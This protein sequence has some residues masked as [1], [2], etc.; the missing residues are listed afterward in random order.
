MRW[1]VGG[2]GEEEVGKE[3]EEA[4]KRL[5]KWGRGGR[6]EKMGKRTWGQ[7]LGKRWGRG[8]GEEKK[9]GKRR[10]VGEQNRT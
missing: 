1:G 10:W 7:E 6:Q 3:T 8:G 2:H 9:V 4:G 5:K